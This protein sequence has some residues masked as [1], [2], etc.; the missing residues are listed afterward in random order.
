MITVEFANG[1]TYQV[2]T[3]DD[4]IAKCLADGNDPFRPTIVETQSKTEIK[5]ETE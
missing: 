5:T 4:A 1:K 2:E 3:L